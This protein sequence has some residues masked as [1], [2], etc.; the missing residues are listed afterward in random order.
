MIFSLIK[1]IIFIFISF[2]V[3][4]ILNKNENIKL[5]RLDYEEWLENEISRL[6]NWIKT[7]NK[8]LFV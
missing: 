8:N 6:L 1:L 5:I 3:V 7:K 2:T 4:F